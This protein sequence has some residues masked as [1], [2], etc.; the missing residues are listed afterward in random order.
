MNRP[1]FTWLFFSFS[2]R[3]DRT[4]YALGGLLLYLLRLFPVYRIMVASDEA[5]T[6]FWGG[7][8]L[9]AA[10]LSLV[11]HIPLAAKRLQDLDKPGWFGVFFIV[12]DILMYIPLCLIPGTAGPNR[13]GS[14]TNAPKD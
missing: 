3:I 1:P 14:R 9:F 11:L 8:F 4:V 5:G 2:G 6:T 10:G 13:Y 12:A 7:I